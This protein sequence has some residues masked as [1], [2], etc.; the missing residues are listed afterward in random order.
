MLLVTVTT[1]I[2]IIMAILSIAAAGYAY[3]RYCEC[4][5]TET[6]SRYNVSEQKRLIRNLETDVAQYKAELRAIG[7]ESKL[8][9]RGR[10]VEMSESMKHKDALDYLAA[11]GEHPA[12]DILTT[13]LG[14]N[15]ERLAKDRTPIKGS[16]LLDLTMEKDDSQLG[17]ILDEIYS[18]EDEE[19]PEDIRTM[20]A[21]DANPT[22]DD[23]MG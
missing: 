9:M 2:S 19:I 21:A 23:L 22:D 15:D 10:T 18:V 6:L 12:Q 14:G 13:P 1:T 20:P 17:G 7:E 11:S 3:D 4:K 16:G 5:K 8:A